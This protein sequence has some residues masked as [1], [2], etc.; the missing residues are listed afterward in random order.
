ML[1][2]SSEYMSLTEAQIYLG[3]SK[4]KMSKLAREM[5]LKVF[6][7]PLDRRK[8]LVRREDV[9]RLKIPTPRP[10]EGQ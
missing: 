8:K 5:G 1:T 3:V 9:E 10:P 7:D 4:I 2:M 6:T